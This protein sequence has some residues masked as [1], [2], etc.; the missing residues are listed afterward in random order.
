VDEY[1][2]LAMGWFRKAAE[3]GLPPA[4]HNLGRA[5]QVDSVKT[6]VESACGFSA[7]SSSNTMNCF[8]V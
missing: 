2:P 3:A 7:S 5:V 1:K 6:R 4:M 8:Q